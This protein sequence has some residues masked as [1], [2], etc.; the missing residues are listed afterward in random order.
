MTRSQVKVGARNLGS[1]EILSFILIPIPEGL[2]VGLWSL[3]PVL[4]C[5]Y[6]GAL[7]PTLS[8]R[9]IFSKRAVTLHSAIHIFCHRLCPPPLTL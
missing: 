2:C 3:N 7:H 4:S 8:H 6:N 1:Q 9:V 5:L